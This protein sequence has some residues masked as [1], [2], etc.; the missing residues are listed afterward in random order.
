MVFDGFGSPS[1]PKSASFAE[2]IPNSDYYDM[3]D[4]F[5]V[6]DSMRKKRITL[7]NEINLCISKYILKAVIKNQ[8]PIR[9]VHVIYS[10]GRFI[11]IIIVM[12]VKSGI[13][14][15]NNRTKK[16][17]NLVNSSKHKSN[18]IYLLLY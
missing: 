16:I 3:N 5:S 8:S 2:I 4:N 10:I 17:C 13:I 15:D 7:I 14:F 6:Y 18:V 11:N 1:C 12:M 9:S